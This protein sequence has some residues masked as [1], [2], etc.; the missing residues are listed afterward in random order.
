M[1]NTSAV[2]TL[3]PSA[4]ARI[5]KLLSEAPEGTIGVK[6]S[7]PKK[8]CSGLSYSLE[9]TDKAGALDERI[10]VDDAVLFIDNASLLYL[11]GSE[12]D[13]IEDDF[14]A[15]FQFK[16]PNATGMCGC[17]ESFTV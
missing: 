14:Q 8:G 9:Y 13:W 1:A 16:N 12:M 6:L 10:I 11:I 7:T 17:G 4:K 15:A 2:I 3:T 5:K